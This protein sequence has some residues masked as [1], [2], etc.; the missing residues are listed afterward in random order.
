MLLRDVDALGN[1]GYLSISR[2]A[3]R[4]NHDPVF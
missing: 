2:D 1:T 4:P 3:C